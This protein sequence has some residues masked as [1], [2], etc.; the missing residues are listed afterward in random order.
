MAPAWQCCRTGGGRGWPDVSLIPSDVI[1]DADLGPVR[2]FLAEALLKV[3]AFLGLALGG[4]QAAAASD[5]SE[6]QQLSFAENPVQPVA[7]PELA[8]GRLRGIDAP[9]DYEAEGKRSGTDADRLQFMEDITG[10]PPGLEQLLEAYRRGY[11]DR[12]TLERGIRQSRVRNEWIPT[13]E[14]LR[15]M[16]P[17]AGEVLGGWVQSHLSDDEAHRKLADAGVDPAEHQWLYDTTGRPPAPEMMLNLLNRRFLSEDEVRLAIRESDVKNKYIDAILES[18]KYIPPVRTIGVLIANGALTDEQ[19][20]ALY[21]ENG[22][23]PED[24]AAYVTSAHHAK[25]AS[26]KHLA[27][28]EIGTLYEERYIPRDD[29]IGAMVDMGYTAADAGLVLEVADLRRWRKFLDQAVSKVHSLYV[30]HKMADTE[31]QLLL[32]QLG[33]PPDQKADLLALWDLQ[34]QANIRTLTEAQVIKAMNYGVITAEQ[35]KA[36]LVGMGYQPADADV[37]IAI[38]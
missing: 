2:K 32:D 29:A 7:P 27:I 34:K 28:S 11:I 6:L 36:E 23:R 22:V 26:H 30:A 17:G 21:A 38:A 24:A 18:R 37:L 10:E 5:I 33:I 15:F 20:L 14:Q 19:G 4:G 1:A 16:P 12:P 3:L 25:T 35:A 9:F 8:L 31:A 13:V